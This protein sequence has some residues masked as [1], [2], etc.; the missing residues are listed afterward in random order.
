M[1]QVGELDTSKKVWDAIRALHVGAEQVKEARLQTLMSEFDR[2]MMKDVEK[3]DDFVCKLAEISAKSA[4]LGDEMEESKLVKKFHK[5]LPRKKYIH[6]VAS[7][8]PVSKTLL[9]A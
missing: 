8:E 9:V 4:A 6:I 7:L 3:I 5:S 2:L 1:L